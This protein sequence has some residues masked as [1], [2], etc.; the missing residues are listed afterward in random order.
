MSAQLGRMNTAGH[1]A[2]GELSASVRSYQHL[3][4]GISTCNQ[5][6]ASARNYQRTRRPKEAESP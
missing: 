3:R 5:V 4:Q 1:P 2:C 6:S